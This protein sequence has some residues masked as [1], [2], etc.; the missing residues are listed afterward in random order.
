M[1]T[2]VLVFGWLLKA[3]GWTP[4]ATV[5]MKRCP[6]DLKAGTINPLCVK[7]HASFR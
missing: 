1:K 2:S 7:L 3:T 6:P 4:L 5:A